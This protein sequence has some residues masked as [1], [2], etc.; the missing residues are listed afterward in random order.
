MVREVIMGIKELEEII[1]KN[2]GTWSMRQSQGLS[3]PE[4]AIYGNPHPPSPD[5]LGIMILVSIDDFFGGMPLEKTDG[6][7]SNTGIESEKFYELFK[8]FKEYD[9]VQDIWINIYDYD[10]NDKLDKNPY[11]YADTCFLS[12]IKDSDVTDGWF[13]GVVPPDYVSFWED[14]KEPFLNVDENHE[15]VMF[16]WD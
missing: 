6:F 1:N 3:I 11:P 9:T 13:D 16:S 7:A 2:G 14:V 5:S 4:D 8:L 12:I 15:V 10:P